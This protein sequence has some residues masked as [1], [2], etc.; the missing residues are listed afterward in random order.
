MKVS[1][2]RSKLVSMK[3]SGDRSKLVSMKVSGDSLYPSAIQTYLLSAG[4]RCGYSLEN[5]SSFIKETKALKD[6]SKLDSYVVNEHQCHDQ[7]ST[8][9]PSR[10][11]WYDSTQ[12][13]H[14][15]NPP[16]VDF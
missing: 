10:H 3:V 4:D 1:R 5:I 9:L 6:L 16:A 8:F 14:F 12:C 11:S 13:D 2:D 7:K 15:P